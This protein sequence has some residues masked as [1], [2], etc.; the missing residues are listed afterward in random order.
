MSTADGNYSSSWHPVI[1]YFIGDLKYIK[2][3]PYVY[4]QSK[5]AIEQDVEV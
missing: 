1:E 4:S 3:S 2:E 5:Y